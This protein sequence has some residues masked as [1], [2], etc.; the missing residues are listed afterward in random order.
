MKA[1]I[2]KEH[3]ALSCWWRFP[4]IPAPVI[5]HWLNISPNMNMTL[6]SSLSSSWTFDQSLRFL[7]LPCFAFF[8]F[9]VRVFYLFSWNSHIYLFSRRRRRNNNSHWF[10]SSNF[11]KSKISTIFCKTQEKKTK[12]IIN[13]FICE[14]PKLS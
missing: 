3:S 13:N 7:A 12:R 14:L 10:Q 6:N 2:R 4:C 5:R 9:F 1:K 11:M 8:F